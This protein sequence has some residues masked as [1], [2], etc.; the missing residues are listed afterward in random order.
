MRQ[1]NKPKICLGKPGIVEAMD[2]ATIL[3]LA[4]TQGARAS[5][6]PNRRRGFTQQR[7]GATLRAVSVCVKLYSLMLRRERQGLPWPELGLERQSLL[8]Q[9]IRQGFALMSKQALTLQPKAHA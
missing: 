3:I 2:C 4:K 7:N 6:Y 5:R 9:G 8:W 1:D